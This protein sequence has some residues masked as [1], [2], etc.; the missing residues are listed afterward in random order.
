MNPISLAMN[1]LLVFLLL[2]A[3]GFGWRLERRLKALKDN[4]LDFA[5]AVGDLDRASL[6]AAAGL[7][8]LRAATDEGVDLLSSRIERAR[9]LSA[10]LEK[11]NADAATAAERLAAAA[12]RR[13]PVAREPAGREPLGRAPM[14]SLAPEPRAR[15]AEGPVTDPV[16]AVE[17]LI[18]R[19]S[20]HEMIDQAPAGRSAPRAAPLA[21]ARPARPRPVADDDLF[22]GPATAALRNPSGARR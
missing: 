9:E 2:L 15:R 12:P 17:N 11:L 19:L 5:K 14:R 16:A 7:A 10:K 6:R 13:E 18:L 20:E 21:E 22:E 3:L 8:E 4:H 1:L